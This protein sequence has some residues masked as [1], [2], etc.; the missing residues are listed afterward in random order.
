M[1]RL[2]R[3]ILAWLLLP[4]ILLAG[5][6]TES[7]V[8]PNPTEQTEALTQTTPATQ[9]PES[10]SETQPPVEVVTFGIDVS[11][12]QGTIDWEAVAA[13]GVEFAMIRV[14]YRTQVNGIIVDDSNARYNLQEASKYGIKLGAYFFSSAVTE[15]EAVEEAQ[16]TAD[17]ISQYPI[18]YPVAFDYEGFLDPD[19]RHYGLT[20][21]QRTDI[22]L[23]FLGT[24]ASRG[25]EP[26]FYGASSELGEDTYW[27]ISRIQDASKIWVA[28]YPA[29][30]YPETPSSDYAGLHHM[31]QYTAEGAVPGI[32]QSVDLNVAYFGYDGIRD[33]QNDQPPEEADP[34]VE[35]L[36]RFWDVN[37]Q[38]T[39]KS[40]TNLRD[41]PSQGSDSKVLYTLKNGEVA[42][43]IGYS[44]SGWSKLSLNGQIYYAVSSYL[45]TD[46]S[47]TPPTEPPDDGIQ[48]VFRLVRENV[49][50]KDVVNLRSLPSVT[51]Q[52]SQVVCQL[53]HGEVA[54]RTGINE[55]VGW[56]RVEYN[57][58][59]LYCV[60]SYLM[61][62]E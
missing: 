32:T 19:N 11:V 51:H 43:R 62:T 30:A 49:T 17:F 45:T 18:T 48:T 12:Y 59:T 57:G 9:P 42:T 29:L 22:A 31:W 3:C 13:S 35:A 24:I 52:D 38:V 37:E 56:S 20:G 53:K 34:D 6:G 25:Y 21:T 33:P 14:G 5:C 41:I 7:S 46:L 36:V 10:V 47:Y 27:E 16:W 8:P 15:A 61:I 39:A 50:A 44:D 1:T 4:A 58:Q 60:S 28:Q 26:M 55:D 54:V 40:E 23:A 2:T